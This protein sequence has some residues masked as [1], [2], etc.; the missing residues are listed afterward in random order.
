MRSSQII[1]LSPPQN[2]ENEYQ[3]IVE[4]FEAGLQCFHLRKPD[5]SD[6]EYAQYLAEIPIEYWDRIILHHHYHL[7]EQLS[8]GGV[9][10]TEHSRKDLDSDS[11]QKKIT[12][13]K[14]A[15]LKVSAAIHD[16]K[17]LS[18]LGQWCDYVLISP[19]F[20]SISKADYKAN[21]DLKVSNYQGKIKAKLFALGGIKAENVQLALEKNFDGVAVLGY[22]W[23]SPSD[24]VNRYNE[25]T[26]RLSNRSVPP[27]LPILDTRPFVLTFAGHDPSSGAGL[28]ADLKTFEQNEVYGLSI[29]TALTVQTD[30]SFEKTNWVELSLILDQAI[31]IKNRFPLK[32]IKIGLIENLEV[33]D[34][35]TSP[36]FREFPIVFDPILRAS[37]GFEFHND[38]ELKKLYQYLKHLI[39][40]TPNREEIL[41]LVPNATAKSA[42][43]FLSQHCAVLLK[44]GHHEERLGEDELWQNGK[45]IATFEAQN[46]SKAGKHGSGC[47]LSAAI[48]A[49]LAKGRSLVEACRSAKVYTEQ[50]LNSNEGLLGYHYR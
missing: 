23:G 37:A 2:V 24:V 27:R 15:H 28:N 49:N 8:L 10:L 35:I 43:Q 33:L 46:I 39:L 38:L 5:F 17:D 16:L 29:C 1:V 41:Q 30:V 25:I 4:L 9:H 21:T 42:A 40:I 12:S 36:M 20:D 22:I 32:A 47:V 44:G 45:K 7:A 6:I 3:I 11:L 31:A 13:Y 48:T 34:L 19:V 26:E 18:L 14:N 50:F